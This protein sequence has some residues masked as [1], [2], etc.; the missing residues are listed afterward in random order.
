MAA[1]NDTLDCENRLE[2]HDSLDVLDLSSEDYF[3]QSEGYE[4]DIDRPTDEKKQKS[5]E[6]A[7]VFAAKETARVQ[8][9]RVLVVSSILLIGFGL[10]FLTYQVL[11]HEFDADS[12]DPVRIQIL[13]TSSTSCSPLPNY[14]FFRF[15]R[16]I[17]TFRFL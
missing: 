12:H 14:F 17:F 4:D 13:F 11:H 2:G 3:S 9:W 15:L 16:R 7:P 6:D 5:S 1:N 10:S 8:R